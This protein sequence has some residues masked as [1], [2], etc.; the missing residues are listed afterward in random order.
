MLFLSGCKKYEVV[1]GTD[2]THLPLAKERSILYVYDDDLYI[3]DPLFKHIRCI[4]EN[5]PLG[6]VKLLT[7]SPKHDKIAYVSGINRIVIVDTLFNQLDL[8]IQ[9]GGVT[10]MQWASDNKTLVVL[11]YNSELFQYFD[12]ISLPNPLVSFPPNSIFRKI[13]NFA[14]DNE[15]N[16]A[17]MYQY[18]TTPNNFYYTYLL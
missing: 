11:D 14:I 4:N 16:I 2:Y 9:P 1:Y 6:F 7:F 12:T 17:C 10:D 13:S 18:K 5:K 8:I 15:G 3:T